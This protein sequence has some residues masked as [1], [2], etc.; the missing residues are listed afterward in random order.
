MPLDERGESVIPF[1]DHAVALV[2]GLE[3]HRHIR[4]R[5]TVAY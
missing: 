3:Q 4:E 1:E 2:D 5:I